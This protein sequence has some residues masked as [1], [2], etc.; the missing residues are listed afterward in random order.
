MRI[1]IKA[2]NSPELYRIFYTTSPKD[3]FGKVSLAK[4]NNL[5]RQLSIDKF[6]EH[7]S[8]NLSLISSE[9]LKLEFIINESGVN[10]IERL[11]EES[12]E[13]LTY[14]ALL[15]AFSVVMA[16]LLIDLLPY[17]FSRFNIKK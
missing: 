4:V 2:D 5:S 11:K 3:M 9:N 17:V 1:N 8:I 14:V 6:V 15:S 7:T 13:D 12:K 10:I 16:R